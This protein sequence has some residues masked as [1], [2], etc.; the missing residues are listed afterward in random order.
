MCIF[1]TMASC[2][3]SL[4]KK[5]VVFVHGKKGWIVCNVGVV[6]NVRKQKR[7]FCV[8]EQIWVR[9]RAYCGLKRTFQ[10]YTQLK[11]KMARSW[12]KLLSKLSGNGLVLIPVHW[13]CRPV[14]V[15]NHSILPMHF[16]HDQLCTQKVPFLLSYGWFSTPKTYCRACRAST[17]CHVQFAIGFFIWEMNQTGAN[18]APV[19]LILWNNGIRIQLLRNKF[20]NDSLSFNL[21]FLICRVS[22]G[23]SQFAITAEHYK[24]CCNVKLASPIHL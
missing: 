22:D 19:R 13:V 14:V 10:W 18:S 20:H 9:Y 7:L 1:I 3:M 17:W 6:D 8:L 2:K 16:S 23:W 24:H 12:V 11:S 15:P 5:T 4:E 21:V